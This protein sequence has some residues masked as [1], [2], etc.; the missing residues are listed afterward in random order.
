MEEK[1]G[2]TPMR[3]N[4]PKV[5]R[6]RL[7]KENFVRYGFTEG[8]GGRK[9]ILTGGVA[10]GVVDFMMPFV[11]YRLLMSICAAWQRGTRHS[12]SGH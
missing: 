3:V 9:A 8:C 12:S 5:Y 11:M 4:E 10:S 1:A 7:K 2:V 6:M